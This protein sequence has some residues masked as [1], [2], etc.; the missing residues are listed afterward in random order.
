MRT[1]PAGPS[2]GMDD[3]LRRV[4]VS[5]PGVLSEGGVPNCASEECGRW[6][7]RVVTGGRPKRFCCYRCSQVALRRK[8]GHKPSK[9]GRRPAGSTSERFYT[10]EELEWLKAVDHYCKEHGRVMPDARGILAIARGLG[11]T[12]EP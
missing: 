5:R 11:Y 1:P 12:K 4:N 3:I 9:Y 2:R 7:P 8:A 10:E 6:F